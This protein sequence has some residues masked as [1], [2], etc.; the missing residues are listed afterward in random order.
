MYFAPPS[1]CTQHHG[2]LVAQSQESKCTFS[3]VTFQAA[4]ISSDCPY[5]QHSVY[6]GQYTYAMETVGLHLYAI[7]QLGIEETG[8]INY[9]VALWAHNEVA[10]TSVAQLCMRA[11]LTYQLQ[12][13]SRVQRFWKDVGVNTLT[14][15]MH[16]KCAQ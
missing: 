11:A 16:S 10:C 6:S 13:Y 3:P 14:R 7:Y 2:S 8:R 9:D 1:F 12:L 4:A 15:D 5:L